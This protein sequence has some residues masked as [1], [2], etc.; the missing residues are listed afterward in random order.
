MSNLVVRKVTGRLVKDN[1]P[2]LLIN[3]LT[4]LDGHGAKMQNNI[5]HGEECI[6]S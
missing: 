3:R 2:V 4:C 1:V 6:D 5:P